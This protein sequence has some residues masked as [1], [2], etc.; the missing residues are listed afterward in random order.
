MKNYL[1]FCKNVLTLIGLFIFSSVYASSDPKD[2]TNGTVTPVMDPQ[3]LTVGNSFRLSISVSK[4]SDKTGDDDTKTNG[5][6]IYSIEIPSELLEIATEEEKAPSHN[7]LTDMG[8]EGNGSYYYGTYTYNEV[9]SITIPY[10]VELGDR[11][12][13]DNPKVYFHPVSPTVNQAED[14]KTTSFTASWNPV[15]KAVYTLTLIEDGTTKETIENIPSTSYRLTDLLP[16]TPYVYVVSSKVGTLASL[17]TSTGA[18]LI[19]ERPVL[20]VA[21]SPLP[22]TAALESEAATQTITIEGL[23]LYGDISITLETGEVFSTDKS[24]IEKDDE[25]KTVEISFSPT[26]VGNQQDY[27]IISSEYALDLRI[28]LT[29]YGIPP[30]PKALDASDIKASAFMLKWEASDYA[31]NYLITVKDISGTPIFEYDDFNVGNTTQYEIT[32]LFPESEYTYTVKTV[33]NGMVSNESNPITVATIQ[34]AVIISTSIAPFQQTVNTAVSKTLRITSSDLTEKITI[35]LEGNNYFSIDKTELEENTGS[36]IITYHPTTL[37][38]HEAELTLSS[39]P[40]ADTKIRLQGTSMPLPTIAKDATDITS[41][42][43]TANWETVS[44]AEGYLLT[45][46]AGNNVIVDEEHVADAALLN[47]P[48]LSSGITYTYTVKVIKESVASASSNPVNVTTHSAPQPAYTAEKTGLSISWPNVTG[49]DSYI[50]SL[51]E[52]EEVVENYENIP[53]NGT[54]FKF[55]ELATNT[56]YNFEVSSVFGDNKYS[57]GKIQAS[58]TSDT[59]SQL[60]NTSFEYWDIVGEDVSSADDIEPMNWNSFRSG[61]LNIGGNLAR[62]KK[63]AESDDI[64]PGSKGNK[65]AQVWSD[66]VFGIVA[67]GNLTTG[68]IRAN[69][70]TVTDP[71]NHNKTFID[72]D[73]FRAPFVDAPDSMTLWVKYIPKVAKG[74]MARVTA[75]LHDNFSYQDPTGGDKTIE[76]HAYSNAEMNFPAIYTTEPGDTE[77]SEKE[78][79]SEE[80]QRLS[81]PFERTNYYVKPAYMLV[82][83]TTNMTPG[84]GSSGDILYL[85]DIVMIYNPEVKLNSLA[86]TKYVT[87]ESISVPYTLKGTMSS[88]NINAEP[89]VVSVELSDENGDFTTPRVLASLETDLGGTMEA[90]I[91]DDIALSANYKIRIVTTNYPLISEASP[92]FEITTPPAAPMAL[93]A[94]DITPGSFVANWNPVDKATGYVVIV[95]ENEFHVS[96]DQT[97]YTVKNLRPETAYSYVVKT[98]NKGI[99]SEVSNTIQVVTTDGIVLQYEDNTDFNAVANTELKGT[100]SVTGI[101]LVGGISV[102]LTDNAS[103]YF[104]IEQN[105]LPAK[106][107]ELEIKYNSDKIGTHTA[108][109]TLSAAFVDDVKVIVTAHTLPEALPATLIT[110]T[111]FT[112]NWSSS[113]EAESYLL[114]VYDNEGSTVGM[115]N[116]FHVEANTAKVVELEPETDYTYSIKAVISDYISES[117]SLIQVK[118]SPKPVINREI[119]VKQFEQ[120]ILTSDTDAFTITGTNLFGDGK[121]AVTLTGSSHFSANKGS[122]SS[123]DE[124]IITYNPQQAGK[125]KVT[126]TLS[127]P[128]ADD[129]AFEVSGTARP[130]APVALSARKVTLTSFDAAWEAVEGA[131][132]YMLTVKNS[133][134]NAVKGY[135]PL[136][137]ESTETSV[138]VTDLDMLRDYTYI[139]EVVVNEATSLPS[140]EI[141]VRTDPTG[142]ATNTAEKI[143]IYPNP[144]QD[145]LHISG[146][147]S[148]ENYLIVNT[149]GAIVS[150]GIFTEEGIRVDKLETGLYILKIQG[151]SLSFIKR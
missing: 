33:S 57:S 83:F 5:D 145:V 47:V 141:S 27:L 99:F 35:L 72:D 9:D 10:T 123:G 113:N 93:E 2:G 28:P 68:K 106:G 14:I 130:L 95:D 31:D 48:G 115:Y 65:S 59:G 97:S 108:E 18:A 4:M 24:T 7:D 102:S 11:G 38:V 147:N 53:V 132:A 29:G 137:V 128:Y 52:G 149:N 134:G 34:G 121:I 86:K 54:T 61:E 87:G 50:V 42:S 90:R 89:N 125:D 36:V 77:G 39:P 74:N 144:V 150:Q 127:S 76:S 64:R 124:V 80:W 110:P 51:F 22:F 56:R 46:K 85:D 120:D 55:R 15:P 112:A 118:T 60:R 79:I 63:V 75:T 105:Y 6:C 143:S 117:S 69:S 94:T 13:T 8:K 84:K 67:N 19:T 131:Q 116:D 45:V 119:T 26:T 62:V 37:G 58:T 1:L 151:I 88:T 136:E 71:S 12:T 107:G 32:N 148:G 81:I 66:D 30:A 135:D 70:M 21:S 43:F 78:V 3:H 16:N 100:I 98:E 111:S 20:E 91:P 142:L 146:I 129:V 41:D 82:S 101:G 44:D 25:D 92:T 140:N 17:E 40:A 49:A 139:I 96:A 122:V 73:K 109:I 126:V 23:E 114:T 133:R 104:S 138:A 103:G